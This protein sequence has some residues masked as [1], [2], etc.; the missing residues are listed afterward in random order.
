VK[1]L[2]YFKD[3]LDCTVNLNQTRLDLL[4]QKVQAIVSC[5]VVQP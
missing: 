5:L 1:L 4:D 2:N 3:F